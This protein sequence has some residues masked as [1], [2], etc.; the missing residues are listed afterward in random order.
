MHH[1]FS[2]A[3]I[4]LAVAPGTSSP[5]FAHPHVW[6]SAKSTLEVTP[7]GNVLAIRHSWTFDEPFSAYATLGMDTDK[8]GKLS[9]DE[10]TPLAKVNVESL[11]EY[12]FFTF[13]RKGKAQAAFREPESFFLEHDGKALTLHFTLPLVD[14]TVN[15]TELRLEVSDPS[16]FVAFEFAKDNPV[17]VNGHRSQCKAELKRPSP[18]VFNRLSQLGEGAF[19]SGKGAGLGLDLATTV[20]FTCR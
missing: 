18:G 17:S 20:H 4:V 14:P 9:R 7:D 16:F 2:A 1:I 11:H 10:L 13:L 3:L 8:D 5:A 15:V 6:V 12:G 19:E